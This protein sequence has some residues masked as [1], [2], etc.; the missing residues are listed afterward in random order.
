MFE[1]I[2][3]ATD[4]SAASDSIVNCAE[5]FKKIGAEKIYLCHALGLKHIEDLKYQMI[6]MVEPKLKKQKDILEK[7][8]LKTE[9]IIAPGIPPIEINRIAEEKE[10]S[11]IVIGSHGESLVSHLFFRFGRMTWEILHSHRHPLLL[12]RTKI[13]ENKKHEICVEASCFDFRKRVL[14]PTDFSDTSYRAFNYLEEI[15]KRGCKKA[16]LIHIQEKASIEKHLEHKLD[17][18]NRIDT[19]RL[20]MLKKRLI[21]RG[22]EDVD[23]K[24]SYGNPTTEILKEVN[25]DDYSLIVMGSQGRGLA[26]EVFLGSVSCNLARNAPLSLLLIPALR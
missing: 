25:R 2:L 1:K 24:I 17:E 22:A 15:V 12:V 13:L 10:I 6:P 16:T 18:F 19:E 26:K 23:V 3:I 4:L 21:E 9:I 5:G 11:L 14:F 20:D 7:N 8:D